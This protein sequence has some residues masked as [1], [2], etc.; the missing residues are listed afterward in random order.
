M[1]IERTKKNYKVKIVFLDEDNKEVFNA[2]TNTNLIEDLHAMH[3]VVGL[4]ELYN[5]AVRSFNNTKEPDEVLKNITESALSSIE[6]SKVEKPLEDSFITTNADEWLRKVLSIK[7]NLKNEPDY[8][9]TSHNDFIEDLNFD[10]EIVKNAKLY[11]LNSVFSYKGKSV[12]CATYKY[13]R[14][15][16]LKEFLKDKQYVLYCIHN[17]VTGGMLKTEPN[18][19]LPFVEGKGPKLKFVFRGVILEEPF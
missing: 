10:Y 12:V 2:N 3:G 18:S 8:I 14:M 19:F 5:S 1:K 9:R 4:Q 6:K 7:R 13:D 11:A 15:E 17:Y 16:D